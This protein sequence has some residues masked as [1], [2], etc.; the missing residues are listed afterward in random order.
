L[1]LGKG[2]LCQEAFLFSVLQKAFP[3]DKFLGDPR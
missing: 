2:L 3:R 1:S